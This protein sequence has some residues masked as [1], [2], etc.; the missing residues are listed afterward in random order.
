MVE[1]GDFSGSVGGCGGLY[2]CIGG[3]RDDS[4]RYPHP[5]NLL[6]FHQYFGS[7]LC[8]LQLRLWISS[9]D[10]IFN[11][12]GSGLKQFEVYCE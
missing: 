9:L 5:V 4:V 12:L 10:Q 11:N 3:F 1:C 8:L 6:N 2:V 7:F